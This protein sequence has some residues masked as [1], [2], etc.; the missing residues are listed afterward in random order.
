MPTIETPSGASVAYLELEGSCQYTGDERGTGAN[1]TFAV[2]QADWMNLLEAL[3]GRYQVNPVADP[4]VIFTGPALALPEFEHAFVSTWR[5]GPLMASALAGNQPSA[6]LM[7]DEVVNYAV[8]G[9]LKSFILEVKYDSL[10]AL[11]PN[12][13]HPDL[14][15]SL[16]VNAPGT[17]VTYDRDQGGEVQ[18]IPS[19]TWKWPDDTKVPDDVPVG[20]VIP[21]ANHVLTWFWVG[22]PPWTRIRQTIGKVN[23]SAFLGAP[24]GTMLF[25]GCQPTPLFRFQRTGPVLYKLAYRFAEQSKILS[26]GTTTVGWNYQ[27]NATQISSENWQIIENAN[28]DNPYLSTDFLNLFKYAKGNP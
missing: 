6:N 23:S 17:Y 16:L 26:D 7:R 1:R 5:A 21:S 11:N 28:D 12:D 2:Q 14:S 18:L 19:R 3:I 4:P 24:A 22:D 8:T 15:S 27:Y 9:G 13:V 10:F 25:L 20:I